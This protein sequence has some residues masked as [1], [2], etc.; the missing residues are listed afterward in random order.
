MVR[1]A[2]RADLQLTQREEKLMNTSNA[3][4]ALSSR[5]STAASHSPNPSEHY[6][7]ARTS[8]FRG[9]RTV[10]EIAGSGQVALNARYTSGHYPKLYNV[11]TGK[12]GE[13][14]AYG[15]Y[16]SEQGGAYVAKLDAGSLVESWRAPLRLPDHWNYPGAMAVL[17]DGNVYAVAGN[18]LARV[19]AETGEAQHLTLPQHPGQG[20][21]AYNG[22]VVSPDGVLFTKSLER[23]RPCQ[24]SDLTENLGI[25]CAAYHK[26]PSFLVAVDTTSA[27]LRIIAQTETVEFIM[28]R[29]ATERHDGVDYV[30][31]PSLGNLWRYIFTG[32]AFVLD[33]T[34]GPVPYAGTGTPGTAPAIMGDWVI[35]QNNGFVS[36]FEPFTIRA[37]NIHDSS[38]TFTHRPLEGYPMSQVGSK[39]AVDPDNMRVYAADWKAGRVVCLDFDPRQGFTNRW[40]RQQTMF[41]FPSLFGDAGRRQ[42]VGTDYDA[43][44]G[45]QVVWRDAATGEE[46]A[47]SA[48]LDPHFNGS[49]VGAGF[50]GTFYYLAQT[51]KAIVELTPVPSPQG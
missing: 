50:D 27:E 45:D 5:P 6:D 8:L 13:L 46:V 47:R 28:S 24:Q 18:L 22:F 30:Y 12:S 44:H 51:C 31:C 38:L 11:S 48:Y 10:E 39:A 25:P 15:G 1:A 16:V 26:I 34:W 17:G 36:S 32:G 9:T 3:A 43:S 19:N 14:F 20:G 29:I 2:V 4:A 41:C 40:V 7:S 21:A 23:G 33:E 37:I 42:L 49:T 35:I